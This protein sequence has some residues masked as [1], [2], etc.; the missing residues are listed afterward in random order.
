[1][2]ILITGAAGFIGYHLAASLSEAGHEIVGLDNINNYYHISLKLSR[3]RQLGIAAEKIRYNK[4]IPGTAR[5]NF[6]FIKLD[7]LDG[8]HLAEL[9]RAE[10]FDMVCNLAAQVGVRYSVENPAAYLASNVDGFFNVLEKCARFNIQHL[11][12]ASSSSVYGMNQNIPFSAKDA[13]EHPISF[14]AATKKTN[15]LFAHTYSY[16]HKL[17]TTGLRFFT[18][19]GPWGRPDMAPFIFTRKIIN[20]EQITIFNNGKLQRDFTYV[21]DIVKGIEAVLFNIPVESGLPVPLTPDRSSAPYRIYNIGNSKPVEIMEFVQTIENLTG[22]KANIRYQPLQPGD[23]VET[24]ADTTMLE[25]EFGFQPA[26]DLQ[27]GLKNFV[28]WYRSFHGV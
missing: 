18:V 27:S 12:Y 11:V 23:L 25:R 4:M 28:E 16:I 17:P 9:F 19:Y 8:E 26:F 1:M 21:T 24:C 2:K 14:Y 3:L 13:V 20:E 6:R 5:S 7:L 15:E 22:K 10:K